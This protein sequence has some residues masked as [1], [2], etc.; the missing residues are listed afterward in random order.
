MSV[1]ELYDANCLD[2]FTVFPGQMIYLPFIPPT[3]TPTNTFTPV[4]PTQTRTPT[5]TP[6]RTETPTATPRAP[7]IISS[8]PDQG[9]VS[10]EVIIA[11]Q[12]R[13]FQPDQ[14]GFTAEL[15]TGGRIQSLIL[16]DLATSTG[17]EARVPKD[18][19]PGL[20]DLWVI[21]PD[22]QFDVRKEA[23][24]AL[25]VTPESTPAQ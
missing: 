4:T 5:A 16:G 14:E 19:P 13:Y 23:Y 3:P 11:I 7:E 22:S 24:E 15:R 21:N 10:E 18:I 6:T 1:K 17:F 25:E 9:S 8:E 20:Y 2:S 12:G